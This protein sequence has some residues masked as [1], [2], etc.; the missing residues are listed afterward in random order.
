MIFLNTAPKTE[1]GRDAFRA[2]L[3]KVPSATAILTTRAPGGDLGQTITSTALCVAGHGPDQLIVSLNA[4]APVVPLLR[5]SGRFAV[6]FLPEDL[7]ELAR[8]YLDATLPDAAQFDEHLWARN[9][10]KS[11]LWLERA[12]AGFDC[13]ITGET[14]QGAQHSFTALVDGVISGTTGALLYRDGLLRRL[15]SIG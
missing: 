13:S 5:K 1:P 7:P 9:T 14:V 10:P 12:V 15:E 3:Q 4:S 8:T 2:A 6:S 11:A